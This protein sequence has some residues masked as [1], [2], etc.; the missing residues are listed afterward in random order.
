MLKVSQTLYHKAAVL[1]PSFP[2]MIIVL[3]IT[4]WPLHTRVVRAEVLRLKEVAGNIPRC[5]AALTVPP[6][7]TY[8]EPRRGEPYDA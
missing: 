4:N 6:P 7:R 1:G 5:D 3:G 2:N 8:T